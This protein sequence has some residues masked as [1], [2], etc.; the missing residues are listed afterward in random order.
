MVPSRF[1]H[2]QVCS[3]I[4]L[5]FDIDDDD[6]SLRICEI[7]EWVVSVLGRDHTLGVTHSHCP[8]VSGAGCGDRERQRAGV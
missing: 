7:A 6:L 5:F 8:G 2:V 4:L 3:R 1:I